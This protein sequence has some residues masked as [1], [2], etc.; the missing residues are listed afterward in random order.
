MFSRLP[1]PRTSGVAIG[2]GRV[3]LGTAFMAFPQQ[4]TMLLGLDAV[5]ATRITWLARM[6]AA[7]DIALGVGTVA[8]S[9]NGRDAAIWLLGGAVSDAVD[10]AAIA[11]AVYARRLPA[12]RAGAMVVLAAGA[13]AAG[14]VLAGQA[15]H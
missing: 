2:A 15:R 5:T 14:A 6:T 10:A 3:A 7:R 9:V 1:S 12:A 13:A 4:S 11:G 8:S